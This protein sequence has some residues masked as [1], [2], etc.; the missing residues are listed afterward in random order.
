MLPQFD[1]EHICNSINICRHTTAYCLGCCGYKVGLIWHVDGD[2]VARCSGC[3]G[4][5]CCYTFVG[6][7]QHM[8]VAVVSQI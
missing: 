4:G 5:L 3:L 7:E 8:D 2:V 6:D 1:G